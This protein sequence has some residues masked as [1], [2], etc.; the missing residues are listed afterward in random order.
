MRLK[1]FFQRAAH[2]AATPD[3]RAACHPFPLL[4]S[5]TPLRGQECALY[6]S[7]REAVPIVDAAI[8]KLVRLC[9]SFEV[10]C[11]E[12]EAAQKLA[13]FARS[14][15]VGYSGRGLHFFISRYL[16]SLL[17]YGT[18]VG[19]IVPTPEGD[20]ISALVN[21]PLDLLEVKA[22]REPLQ[23]DFY[24][25]QGGRRIPVRCPQWLL[26]TALCPSD[27]KILGNSLLRSLPFVSSILLAIYSSIG[28]NFER[29]ANLRYA[30][31]YK[32]GSAPMDPAGAKETAESLAAQW[33]Q[34]ISSSGGRIRDFV[35][36][37]DV[38]IK[39]IGADNQMIDTEVP[40]RQMLEEI[41]AKLGLPPFMLGLSWSTSERMSIQQA[42][43]LTAE[44][45]SYRALIGP[46]LEKICGA[47][48]QLWGYDCP[49]EIHWNRIRLRD[50]EQLANARYLNAKADQLIREEEERH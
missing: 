17:T 26:F 15:Q 34:A 18:A 32:P 39:V 7:I 19:E 29:I 25:R 35:A 42:D 33:S 24:L 28:H 31:V 11:P 22:G 37:G 16:D 49:A 14:V 13:H 4:D 38:E 48:L 2:A 45:E 8:D 47:A 41:V 6:D 23:L 12:E 5:Y 10:S 36:V 3:S 27:G 21:A 1:Q 46:V 44:I 50:E 40:V 20:G 30:V 9:C 43:L